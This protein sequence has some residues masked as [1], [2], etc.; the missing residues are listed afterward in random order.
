MVAADER[1]ADNGHA[2]RLH[3]FPTLLLAAALLAGAAAGCD[4]N[5]TLPAPTAGE[6]G[7]VVAALVLR[8]ATITD[9]VAGDAGC[10]DPTLFGNAVRL[11][12]RMPGAATSAPVYV[13]R[14]K[15]AAD[16]DAA[17]A[18]FAACVAQ[19]PRPPD[20]VTTVAVSPWRAYGPDW[21]DALR[22]AVSAALTEAGGP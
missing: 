12:V 3:R 21:P 16:Y 4:R 2:M 1:A 15:R 20:A 7:D 18:A 6:L 9:Q 19:S 11:D 8:G 22:D 17:E 5:V 13:L 14:W 10:S